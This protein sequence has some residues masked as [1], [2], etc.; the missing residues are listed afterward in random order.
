LNQ[1]RTKNAKAL[2]S[3]S[4]L[5]ITEIAERI[6]YNSPGTF[7]RIFKRYESVTPGQYRESF[8]NMEV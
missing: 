6:G 5:P 1:C 2:L 8:S 3:E 4:G 7:I